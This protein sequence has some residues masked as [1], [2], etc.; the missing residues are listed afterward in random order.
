M[1]F[2][3]K[4]ASLVSSA[5]LLKGMVVQEL[6]MLHMG[7]L[8]EK[9]SGKSRRLEMLM[10]THLLIAWTRDIGQPHLFSPLL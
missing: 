6:A 9:S 1:T 4:W 7:S 2:Y 3:L 10:F 5:R 8:Q